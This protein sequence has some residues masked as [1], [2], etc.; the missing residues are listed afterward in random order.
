MHDELGDRMKTYYEN[1]TKVFLPRRSYTII[2]VDGKAFHTY[3]KGLQRP[4]DDALM[5]A[6]DSTA[7]YLCK[8][9]MGA[10]FA[11][12]Q[13][14][15]ISILLTDFENIGTQAWFDN[16]VQKM[17]SVS[18]SM[19]T[20]AFNKERLQ[21]IIPVSS[22]EYENFKFAEFD[23]RIFQIPV[24]GEVENY[25]IWRQQDTVRNSIQSVAHD[26]YSQKTLQGKNVNELQDLIFAKG[27]NWNDYAPKYKRGRLIHK[28]YYPG[29]NDSIRTTWEVMEPT[30]DFI[31]DRTILNDLIPFSI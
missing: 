10:K 9:I 21:Q 17:A 4:F 30:P 8:N 6:I 14:D 20:S 13:S 7:K 24:K 25:F 5:T 31:K 23:S 11:F 26:L 16:N 18:A 27:I 2:R 28:I 3:T 15:E 1:R 19:A 29:E 12:V 22:E